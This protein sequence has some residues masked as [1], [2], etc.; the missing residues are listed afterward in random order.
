M[1]SLQQKCYVNLVR[2]NL[3]LI[4]KDKLS[5]EIEIVR[6]YVK[7]LIKKQTKNMHASPA[8]PPED[9]TVTISLPKVL[10]VLLKFA[11]NHSSVRTST[12]TSKLQNVY[13][14]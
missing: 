6:L 10:V 2:L 1:K 7:R 13:L 8:A 4:M 14:I 11:Y 5:T 3:N 9:F 12:S